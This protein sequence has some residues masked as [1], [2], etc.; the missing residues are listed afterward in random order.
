[1]SILS[2]QF[3][4]ANRVLSEA[5]CRLFP[6]VLSD[7]VDEDAVLHKRSASLSASVIGVSVTGVS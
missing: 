1:M 6:L 4:L 2:V 7:V 3:M 5:V